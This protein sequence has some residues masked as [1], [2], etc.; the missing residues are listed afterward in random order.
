VA[1]GVESPEV[2]AVLK[3]MGCD[4]GQGYYYGRPML[5]DDV[6][7]FLRGL[8]PAALARGRHSL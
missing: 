4:C 6:T 3:L 2:D 5:A 1:E 8:Q 7:T